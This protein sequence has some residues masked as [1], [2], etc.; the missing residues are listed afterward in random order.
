[1][2]AEPSIE[3]KVEAVA[4]LREQGLHAADRS[5]SFGDS[6]IVGSGQSWTDTTPPIGLIQDAH[7]V[8]LHEGRWSMQKLAAKGQINSFESLAAAVTAIEKVLSA[9]PER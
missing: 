9:P 5:W 2:E 4:W 6:L 7:C 3:S 1:M 8:F